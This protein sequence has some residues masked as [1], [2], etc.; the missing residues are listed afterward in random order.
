M[1]K[2]LQISSSFLLVDCN[3]F[4]SLE[5]IP[6]PIISPSWQVPHDFGVPNIM[7]APINSRLHFHISELYTM[8]SLGLHVM[9]HD[10]HLASVV[11]EGDGTVVGGEDKVI[12][13][14]EGGEENICVLK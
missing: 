2:A 1:A 8:A 12:C 3:T 10:P 7:G 11:R 14:V 9:T 5:M 4:I 6:H 13:I